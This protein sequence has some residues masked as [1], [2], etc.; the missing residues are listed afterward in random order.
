[1][2]TPP[3]P[4]VTYTEETVPVGRLNVDPE[5]QRP[6]NLAKVTDIKRSFNWDAVGVLTVSSRGADEYMVVLDGQTRLQVVKELTDNT[7]V[8]PC[9]VFRGLT[10]EQ[11]ALLFL[12]LNNTTKVRP[13]DQFRVKVTAEDPVAVDINRM[14]RSY[15][16]DVGSGKNTGYVNAV[17]ALQW[18]YRKSE[19]A[20]C[21]PNLVQMVA[22]VTKR[23]WGL[24]PDG[25]TGPLI[26]GLGLLF[27]VHSS[28]IEVDRLVE[29]LS[30]WRNGPVGLGNEASAHAKV[31][32]MRVFNAVADL[33]SIE[34]SRGGGQRHQ[35]GTW[36]H[37]R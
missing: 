11:E 3:V 23:A 36:P 4:G 17:A 37:R 25:M 22:L 13:L 8:L 16:W 30:R 26:K 21:E 9:R 6:L 7:G 19:E 15:G 10:K 18:V 31:Q 33:V 35:L 12:A 2:T 34:Y 32:S 5:V 20:G 24:D 14:I 29:R 27:L 28:R 1:M